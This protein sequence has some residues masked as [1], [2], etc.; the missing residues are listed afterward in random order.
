MQQFCLS[1]SQGY[2]LFGPCTSLSN[3]QPRPDDFVERRLYHL[4]RGTSSEHH[5][6]V[7]SQV[8]N[9]RFETL[10]EGFCYVCMAPSCHEASDET[11]GT[12]SHT[13]MHTEWLLGATNRNPLLLLD[14]GIAG[15]H[16]APAVVTVATAGVRRNFKKADNTSGYDTP[17]T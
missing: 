4:L 2:S 16:S 8:S 9:F 3:V 11:N 13:Q 5:R 10:R 12:G 6:R 1:S 14:C 17:E 15:E 7:G